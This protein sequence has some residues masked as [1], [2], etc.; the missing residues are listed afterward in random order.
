MT[1][2]INLVAM[3]VSYIISILSFF[4]QSEFNKFSKFSF[5]LKFRFSHFVYRV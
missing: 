5:W 1:V 3:T 2:Y 4:F